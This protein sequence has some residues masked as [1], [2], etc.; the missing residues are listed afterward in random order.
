[1]KEVIGIVKNYG[2][3]IIIP[4]EV[5]EHIQKILK[6]GRKSKETEKA[7]VAFNTID[8]LLEDDLC[9]PL[10]LLSGPV[11]SFKALYIENFEKYWAKNIKLCL[12]TN[13]YGLAI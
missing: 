13:D 1:M 10:E 9:K 5:L 8:K 7:A 4:F 12:I 3:K 2:K 6:S 11:P